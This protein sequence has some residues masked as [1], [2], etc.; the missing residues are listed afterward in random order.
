MDHGELEAGDAGSGCFQLRDVRLLAARSTRVAVRVPPCD[1]LD[2]R[3]PQERHQLRH[4][5]SAGVR[6]LRPHRDVRL[7]GYLRTGL[8]LGYPRLHPADPLSEAVAG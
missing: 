5:V 6:V 7:G 3:P 1:V 4:C 2:A 8:Y